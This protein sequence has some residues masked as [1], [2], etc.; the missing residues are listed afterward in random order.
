MV[1]YFCYLQYVL[2]ACCL[3][4]CE[5]SCFLLKVFISK[6]EL[7]MLNF[8]GDAFVSVHVD[9]LIFLKYVFVDSV[10]LIFLCLLWSLLIEGPSTRSYM[11]IIQVFEHFLEDETFSLKFEHLHSF[12]GFRFVRKLSICSCLC[13]SAL[14]CKW[15][16]I[17]WTNVWSCRGNLTRR[18]L[19]L[20]HK[21]LQSASFQQK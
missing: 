1:F 7:L 2:S 10:Q 11:N 9:V 19:Y 8:F 3:F 12:W 20:N 14:S 16:M 21:K 15:M 13:R 17:M 6:E 5:Q 4:F 18:C